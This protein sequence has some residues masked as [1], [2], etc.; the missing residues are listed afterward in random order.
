[1]N[2]FMDIEV[3]QQGDIRIDKITPAAS[4]ALEDVWWS[5]KDT[6]FKVR[7]IWFQILSL[8]LTC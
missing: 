5:G 8:P 7:K 3:Y 2:Y 1:M 6:G 4:L